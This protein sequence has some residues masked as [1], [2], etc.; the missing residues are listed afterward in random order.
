[1]TEL[2]KAILDALVEI[3]KTEQQMR[4]AQQEADL[5]PLLACIDA[6]SA[7]L[8]PTT[9]PALLKHLAKRDYSQAR[10]WLKKQRRHQP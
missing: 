2:E 3:E 10:A 9:H 1:M 5:L 4:A 8:P 7:K 6:V